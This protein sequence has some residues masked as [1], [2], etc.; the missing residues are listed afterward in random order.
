[1]PSHR[2][3]REHHRHTSFDRKHAPAAKIDDGDIVIFET[4]DSGYAKAYDGEPMEG[5]SFNTVTGPVFIN[6]AKSGDALRVDILDITI[7]RAWVLWSQGPLA[8]AKPDEQPLLTPVMLDNDWAHISERVRFPL[9]PMIGC[10][11]CAPSK[12]Q[13]GLHTPV[14]RWGGN[15]D[16]TETIKGA[17]IYLPVQLRGGLLS[18]GDVHARMGANEG[19]WAGLESRAQVTTRIQIV[20]QMQL[21]SPRIRLDHYT[22]CMAIEDSVEQAC[23]VAMRRAYAYLVEEQSFTPYEA[24][25]YC[26]ACVDLRL[27]GPNSLNEQNYGIVLA[28]IP[29]LNV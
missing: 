24:Y 1:M 5:E 16:L 22:I 26:A 4:D 12:G 6:G 25:A 2:I 18:L 15:L 21:A 29:D 20:P 23:E 28:Y 14:Y 27:G 3:S 7:E 17:S 19:T 10:I 13:G 11:G 8:L 9:R